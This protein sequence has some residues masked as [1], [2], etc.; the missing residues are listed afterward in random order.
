MFWCAVMMYLSVPL[1]KGAVAFL[2][3]ARCLSPHGQYCLEMLLQLGMK[4]DTSH[5][6]EGEAVIVN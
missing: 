1:G 3:T 4:L 5:S 2:V 6:V